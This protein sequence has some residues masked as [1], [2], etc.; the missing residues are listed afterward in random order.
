M[1][2]STIIIFMVAFPIVLFSQ[3]DKDTVDYFPLKVGNI[4]RYEFGT[5]DDIERRE[6]V[7]FSD[8]ANSNIYTV[9]IQNP[10]LKITGRSKKEVIE[11]R[12]QKVL[13]LSS[14]GPSLSGGEE[15]NE[16]HPPEIV[17]QYP[18]KVGSTWTNKTTDWINSF[19]VIEF[20]TVEVKAAIFKNVCKVECITKSIDD[21]KGKT[22]I[23]WK[24]YLYY[25]PNIGLI[26]EV[27]N[28]KGK[29]FTYL[30]LIGYQLP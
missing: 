18:L 9:E 14:S 29:T 5:S 2:L 21:E 20:A 30:E 22:T 25:A 8:E 6:V 26:K 16:F 7:D 4:W 12:G 19:K 11:M 28:T 17:L 15:N 27:W 3:S 24:K 1:K 23:R 13:R 10:M